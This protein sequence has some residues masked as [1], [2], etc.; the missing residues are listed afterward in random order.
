[1]PIVRSGFAQGLVIACDA[2]TEG[3]AVIAC[4]A[5]DAV[6]SSRPLPSAY[7]S[8]PHGGV[9]ILGC[10]FL[11]QVHGLTDTVRAAGNPGCESLDRREP[12]PSDAG[13]LELPAGNRSVDGLRT[14]ATRPM[15]W[16]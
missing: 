1:M 14:H 16:Q 2:V 8:T 7:Q 10:R 6:S 15:L 9:D 11:R 4:I 3:I 13:G 12:L 5:C